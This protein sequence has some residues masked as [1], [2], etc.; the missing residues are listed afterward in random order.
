M[1][2]E[3]HE[4]SGH[5]GAQDLTV[6]DL[7]AVLLGDNADVRAQF[8]NHFGEMI[9]DF[10]S[11]AVRAYGRLQAFGRGV[12]LDRRAAWSEAFL[13]SAFNSSLT[14][15]H[16]LISGLPT[17]AGNLMR[18]YGEACAMALLCSH[19]AI[20]V[21]QRL[22]ANPAG[23]PVDSAVQTVR[24]RRNSELLRLNT[25]P[26][27]SFSRSPS[28]TIPTAMRRCFRWRR[29]RDSVSA[30]KSLSAQ[31]LTSSNLTGTEES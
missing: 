2:T 26:G 17:P 9:N 19:R 29:K 12:V 24:K 14:S 27:R 6:E 8:L 21:L 18:H 11:H 5:R 3:G 7:R 23:F 22:D 31:A 13:F 16:L 1:T 4:T 10:L 28:G 30:G 25:E 15:C 20:D